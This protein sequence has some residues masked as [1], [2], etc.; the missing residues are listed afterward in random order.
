MIPAVIMCLVPMVKSRAAT[1]S[2]RTPKMLCFT[3][4]GLLV[5]LGLR[6]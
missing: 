1:A 4:L 3:T 2:A 6:G 5:M